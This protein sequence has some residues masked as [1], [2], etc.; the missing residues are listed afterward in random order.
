MLVDG[1][2]EYA[3]CRLCLYERQYYVEMMERERKEWWPELYDSDAFNQ[4]ASRNW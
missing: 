3:R 1:S 4:E 2:E